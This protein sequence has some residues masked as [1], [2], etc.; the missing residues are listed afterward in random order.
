MQNTICNSLL[1]YTGKM[2]Y[3]LQNLS[4]LQIN[5]IAYYNNYTSKFI[6][7]AEYYFD[8]F[9]IHTVCSSFYCHTI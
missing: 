1:Q 2:C 9:K 7:Y 5:A 8:S 3:L 4:S 6:P